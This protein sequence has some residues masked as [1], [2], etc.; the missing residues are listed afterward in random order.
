MAA[1]KQ[2][3][4]RD[5]TDI[6]GEKGAELAPLV[7][8][9]YETVPYETLDAALKGEVCGMCMNITASMSGL[10]MEHGMQLPAQRNTRS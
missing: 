5:I 8:T 2:A 9:F 7:E 4:M 6:L 1:S 3:F 10:S